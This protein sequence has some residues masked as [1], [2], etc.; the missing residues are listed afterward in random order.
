[1]AGEEAQLT[2]IATAGGAIV[3]CLPC[4]LQDEKFKVE[5]LYR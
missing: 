4:N 2:Y 1:M 5:I 3:V